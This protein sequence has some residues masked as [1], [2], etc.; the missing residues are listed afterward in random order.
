MVLVGT[1]AFSCLP[2]FGGIAVVTPSGY[3][4]ETD[5][6][7]EF[8][9]QLYSAKYM[10]DIAGYDYML[11]KS[12]EAAMQNEMILLSNVVDSTTF[13]KDEWQ[14]LHDWVEDGGVML[15]PAIISVSSAAKEIVGDMFGIDV[16]KPFKRSTSRTLINWNPEYFGI[17]ELEYIDEEEERETSVG[18]VP[19]FTLSPEG[20][21]I[22]ASFNNGDAAVLRNKVGKG[23]TYVVALSWRDVIQRNQL[24]NDRNSSRKYNNG[25][26]PSSDVWPL[27]LRSIHST[28]ADVSV[29]K[30]TVPGGYSQLLV[31]THDCDSRTAFD[32]MHY[33]AEYED[34]VGLRGH[35]F[36]TTHYYRDKTNF[37][38][39]YLSA[40][41]NEETIPKALDL[42]DFGHTVGSHSIG[43]FPD[44]NKVMN[45]DVVT[46]EE[47]EFRATCE[48]GVSRGVSTWAEII[49]SKQILEEDLGNNVRSFRSGHL[50]VNPDFN[51][52]MDEGEYEFQS[53]YTAGD[54]LSEFPF[55]GRYD[56]SWSEGLSNVLT[57]PLHMSDVYNSKNDV[58]ISDDNWDTHHAVSDWQ[59]A[60]QKLRGN[61][62]SS[63][64][65]IHPNREWKMTLEKRLVES[66]DLAEVGLYNFEDY[67]DFWISRLN[68]DYGYEVDENFGRVTITADMETLKRS[69]LA[70]A[71]ETTLETEPEVVFSDPEYTDVCETRMRQLTG[72]RY[73][74]MPAFPEE[75]DG[76]SS[77]GLGNSGVKGLYD[78]NGRMISV[79]NEFDK[80]FMS[81][82]PKGI[83]ILKDGAS[84]KKIR[85]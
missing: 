38:H 30:F 62:A 16:T 17:K 43:H 55:F 44:F 7:G 49:L 51:K 60:M 61:Y 70:F 52:I 80:E 59:A 22:L 24:N 56:N 18:G 79:G 82:L 1:I 54:L 57:M 21:E 14:L 50:C 20:S 23:R 47:Y 78:I 33:M 73:L 11:T 28:T 63:I 3:T 34:S 58:A 77:I 45:T 68:T 53:C 10:C 84:T 35:Y 13:T 4:D 75:E 27:F 83:Y 9:R 5:A 26:E 48:D 41:Y 32:E 37:G 71:V 15:S 64:I 31:P 72:N 74:A 46:R 36:L 40:F 65:L 69:G 25:F 85:N 67:G 81:S 39:S 66:L 12:I 29:W 8:S 42:L 19:T 2:S 76:V 6:T